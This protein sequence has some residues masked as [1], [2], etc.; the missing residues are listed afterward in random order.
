MRKR[1][2]V[3]IITFILATLLIVSN[4]IIN[5]FTAYVDL[6]DDK[7]YTLSEGTRDMIADIDQT[8][9]VKVLLDGDFPAEFERLKESTADILR[10]F[11]SINPRVE[12][13]FEDP[14][15]G[16]VA[17]V[18]ERRE[19]LRS[20]GILATTLTVMDQGQ[21]TDKLIFPY[22]IFS[23]G[24]RQTA[25]N[26]LEEQ[27]LRSSQEL[28]INRSINLLE[29][30]MANA[31][32]KLLQRDRK[33]I[34]FVEGQGELNK[35][36]T[37][38]LERELGI[39]YDLGRV[40]LDSIYQIT[41]EIDL[42]VIAKPKERYTEKDQFKID[43]Y[44]MNGG[45]VI[46]LLD[47][48]DINLDS[49][50]KYGQYVPREIEHGLD[51]QLF[52]YGV[53]IKPNL[54]LDAEASKIPQVIGVSGDK[55]QTA[56]FKWYYHP[57]AEGN[58]NH[59]ISKNIG[60]TNFIFPSTLDTL[61]TK[62]PLSRTVLASSSNYSR[63]QVYPMRIGFDILQVDEDLSKFNKGSQ[64]IALLAEG[65]FVSHFKNRVPKAMLDGLASIGV[66]YKESSINTQQ[67]FISDGDF[68][69]NLYDR[70]KG[71]ISDIGYNKWEERVY[72]GN[73]NLIINA[74][75]YLLDDYGLLEARSKDVKLR[76]L[77]QGKI[78]SEKTKWQFINVVLPILL[79]LVFGIAFNFIRKRKYT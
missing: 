70:E 23:F 9:Y 12:Y 69:K 29:Y 1:A 51:D 71:R 2:E 19:Y 55:P 44:I 54:I 7:K 42:V 21:R 43:Q 40:Q 18:N 77:D 31:I 59:P 27:T 64:A 79:L 37:G 28:V 53:R 35:D 50:A 41:P 33:S 60:L 67:I 57:L 24:S 73:K 17:E 5:R 6:T 45:K 39:Y 8:I 58:P 56:L 30:K 32:Q 46:W 13:I 48:Y 14:N 10:Q 34:V 63:F 36:Q 11:R 78:E 76:L 47:K 65:E 4:G 75:E 72:P 22:A 15:E 52:S 38:R 3:I 20:Q 16:S 66:E 62:Q 74:I 25:A 26:L 61:K 49:I 68:I